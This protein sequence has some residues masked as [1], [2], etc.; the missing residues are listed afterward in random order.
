MNNS[1]VYNFVKFSLRNRMYYPMVASLCDSTWNPMDDDT[2]SFVE[3]NVRESVLKSINHSISY[4][5][6]MITSIK[7]N[8]L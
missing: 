4:R 3:T 8:E 6:N 2:L 5:I 7:L 1:L